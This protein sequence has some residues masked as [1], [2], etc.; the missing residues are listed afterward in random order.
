MTPGVTNPHVASTYVDGCETTSCRRF[1][2]KESPENAARLEISI[3]IIL[4]SL[5]FVQIKL[6]N[7]EEPHFL[8]EFVEENP[9]NDIFEKK[10][11]PS[12]NLT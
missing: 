7:P 11:V 8:S 2:T 3:G 10:H 12:G 1:W 9:K 5:C 4:L 6:I